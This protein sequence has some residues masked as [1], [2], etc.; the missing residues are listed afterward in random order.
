MSA[1]Q[2]LQTQLPVQFLVSSVMLMTVAVIDLT[3]P[4]RHP[5]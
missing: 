2:R 5:S 1:Q 3:G 4:T